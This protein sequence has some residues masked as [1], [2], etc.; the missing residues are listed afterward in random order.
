M[1][2]LRL[3]PSDNPTVF[4]Q[5]YQQILTKY[6]QV[7]PQGFYSALGDLF[8]VGCPANSITKESGAGTLYKCKG[9]PGWYNCEIGSCISTSPGFWSSVGD[10][11]QH[12]CPLHSSTVASGSVR[13][14]DCQ[15]N[16]GHFCRGV[17]VAV[18]VGENCAGITVLEM[19]QKGT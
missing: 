1:Q 7:V 5:Q 11:D 6:L 3:L 9:N 14:E 18:D 12:E 10:N 19:F 15:G 4:N 16:G 2:E 13:V 17:T 8:P